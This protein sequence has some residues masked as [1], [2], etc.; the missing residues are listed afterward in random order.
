MVYLARS[1]AGCYTRLLGQKGLLCTAGSAN[2]TM[3]VPECTWK[4]RDERMF[5]HGLC[6]NTTCMVLLGCHVAP[7]V[8]RH[9]ATGNAIGQ[10]ASPMGRQQQGRVHSR[11]NKSMLMKGYGSTQMQILGLLM[12]PLVVL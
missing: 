3:P 11:F 2:Y 5:L 7:A 8:P 1:P 4:E 9:P 10:L 6:V 12:R